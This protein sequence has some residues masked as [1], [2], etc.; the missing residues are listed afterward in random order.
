MAGVVSATLQG[1]AVPA[2]A[3]PQWDHTYVISL[4]GT[5]G[6]WGCYGRNAG[7]SMLI[8]GTGSSTVANCL[9][10]LNPDQAG[11]RYG[12]TGVCHQMANRILHPAN[13]TVASCNGYSVSAF[14]YGDYGRGGWPQRNTC[15]PPG[16]TFAQ[17]LHG[18]ALGMPGA[19]TVGVP[20]DRQGALAPAGNQRVIDSI[21]SATSN[22]AVAA[23]EASEMAELAALAQ[24]ALGQPLDPDT[25]RALDGVQSR[26]RQQQAHYVQLFD[27]GEIS[28]EEYLKWTNVIV[29]LAMRQ[30]REV[31]GE[32][33]FQAIFGEA[34]NHPEGLID[35]EAFLQR[36]QRKQQA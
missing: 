23:Q 25:L 22:D 1:W 18:A 12:L 8:G 16:T 27:A 34:G 29:A 36:A 11:I 35:H 3:T 5:V 32:K 19:G 31:L 13:I 33:R 28:A 7:G 21:Y 26:L 14:V 10:Q 2:L 15:Y 20:T 30:N 24:R 9:A 4:C 6:P 17:G